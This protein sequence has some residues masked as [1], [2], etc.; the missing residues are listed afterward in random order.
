VKLAGA[1][2][3]EVH[4]RLPCVLN[5]PIMIP[6]VGIVSP[7]STIWGDVVLVCVPVPLLSGVALFCPVI[8]HALITPA[9]ESPPLIVIV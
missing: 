1:V 8:S 7:V 5:A 3:T 6:P 4:E 2:V 9:A